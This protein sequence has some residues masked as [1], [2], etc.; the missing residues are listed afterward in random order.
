MEFNP[1]PD[2]PNSTRHLQDLTHQEI[3]YLRNVTWITNKH[4]D[5]LQASAGEDNGDDQQYRNIRKSFRSGWT[6]QAAT[7]EAQDDGVLLV[8]AFSGA[9]TIHDSPEAGSRLVLEAPTWAM[10]DDPLLFDLPD[11]P[12]RIDH[13]PGGRCQ[14]A[15]PGTIMV[16]TDNHFDHLQAPFPSQRPVIT[17]EATPTPV[18]PSPSTAEARDRFAVDLWFG[19][20]ASTEQPFIYDQRSGSL[21]ITSYHGQEWMP[22]PD[23]PDRSL[24]PQDG[25]GHCPSDN[26][27]GMP[28]FREED[29]TN[30]Q[31]NLSV[32]D[33]AP[34]DLH[35]SEV[36]ELMRDSHSPLWMRSWIVHSRP[37][38]TMVSSMLS[39]TT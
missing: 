16:P 28:E 13:L 7:A 19:G 38:T 36:D 4:L 23:F 3:M 9:E 1:D 35:R 33:G 17:N 34:M 11:H 22:D 20:D 21:P 27:Q 5:H 2:N 14:T 24:F 29:T 26:F 15:Q 6:D 37:S 12:S 32:A 10:P 39:S 25:R 31:L 30:G 8:G 18:W